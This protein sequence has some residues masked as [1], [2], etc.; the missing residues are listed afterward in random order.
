MNGDL[1]CTLA[2]LKQVDSTN[3]YARDEY[4]NLAD[5][6]LLVAEAQTG[7]R[8]RRGRV[9]QSPPG[10]NLYATFVI[11][12][13]PHPPTAATWLASLATLDLLRQTAPGPAWWIKWPN[14]ILCGDRKVCGVLCET[15][16]AIG[17][18]PT[19]MLIGIGVN[20][21]MPSDQLAAID[22]PATSTL[23]ETG[24][25]VDLKI[26]ASMLGEM[27]ATMYNDAL[28]GGTEALFRRWREENGVLGQ[29]VCLLADDGREIPGTVVDM[30]GSGAILL[31]DDQGHRQF[32]FSGDVSLRRESGAAPGGPD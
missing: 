21:N 31:V 14:D 6:T 3:R 19:G 23:A 1:A 4:A 26:F 12:R 24:R 13:W 17:N 20:L 16:A 7:G 28:C 30:D 18:V 27:L 9:W 2:W 15:Y 22:R 29:R 10:C 11:K 5:A 8:G 32:F 25:S